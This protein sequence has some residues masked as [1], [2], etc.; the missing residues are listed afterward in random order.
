MA[1]T[2]SAACRRGAYI[3]S[4][5]GYS[6]AYLQ[7]YYNNSLD[8]VGAQP[9]TV[10]TGSTLANIDAALTR[11]S[12]IQGVVTGPLGEALFDIAVSACRS[13]GDDPCYDYQTDYSDENGVYDVG[14]LRAGV[15][16]LQFV[17]NRATIWRSISTTR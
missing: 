17:D 4:F 12:H 8:L 2:I 13:V 1:S 15:Y 16:R 7:E 14:G 9:Q 3:I 10:A 5:A 11:H 6:D